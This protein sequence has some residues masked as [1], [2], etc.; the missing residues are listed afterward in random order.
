MDS[1]NKHELTIFR[2][3]ATEALAFVEAA[4]GIGINHVWHMRGPFKDKN[5]HA[6]YLELTGNLNDAK[7]QLAL[8]A[9][10]TGLSLEWE[11]LPQTL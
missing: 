2:A 9:S 1:V 3:T 10:T 11:L 8:A 6:V 5:T 4:E 7:A